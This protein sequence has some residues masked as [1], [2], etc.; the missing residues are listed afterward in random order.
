MDAASA[1]RLL[2]DVA[3]APPP[4]VVFH[5]LA[6]QEPGP[7]AAVD[8]SHAVLVDNGSVWVVATRAAAVVW[9]G[10]TREAEPELHA[11][12]A[13]DAQDAV[14]AAY[15]SFG[16][17]PPR[18][19]TATAWAEAWRAL[20]ELEACQRAIATAP[21][22]GLVL[23]DGALSGLP[24]GPQEMADRLRKAAEGHGVRL[25]GVAKRSALERGGLA[26][27]PHLHATGPAGPWRVEAEPGVHVAKLHSQAPHAFRVDA[28]D[29]AWLGALLPLCRDAVYVGY[30]YPLAVAHNRA[31]L[32]G[33]VVAELKARLA[34]AARAEGG[35]AAAH[36]LADF[37]EV[38]DRNVPG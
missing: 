2:L 30:P 20:R 35:V 8:G 28:Q 4:S 31:A 7:V 1:V 18:T 23:L 3:P 15:L 9:P 26:L 33:G 17:E 36:L 14:S 32:T 38:L 16:L 13:Q 34:L 12:K 19:A 5:P 22:G 24:P 25:V 6:A 27:V 21:P 10:P 29:L 11:A 37:H